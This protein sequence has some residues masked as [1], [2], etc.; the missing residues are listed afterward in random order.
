MR[1]LNWNLLVNSP[2]CGAEKIHETLAMVTLHPGSH[3]GQSF[4]ILKARLQ[5]SALFWVLLPLPHPVFLAFPITLLFPSLLQEASLSLNDQST[6][7]CERNITYAQFNLCLT[8][9]LQYGH[10]HG[11]EDCKK[12]WKEPES[13]ISGFWL[14]DTSLW[15]SV[16][17]LQN[18]SHHISCRVLQI[19]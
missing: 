16:L 12:L 14:C 17:F 18:G 1:C 11:A 5:W 13:R 15:A 8:E 19:L 10:P 9:V 2:W 3:G 7:E 6:F 4:P